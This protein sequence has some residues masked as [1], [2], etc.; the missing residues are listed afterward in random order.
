MNIIHEQYIG[1]YENAFSEEYCNSV[2]TYFEEM[3]KSGNTQ[4]RQQ[5]DGVQKSIKENTFINCSDNTVV[6]AKNTSLIR[7]FNET[8]WTKCYSDYAN[9]YWV[10]NDFSNHGSFAFRIQKTEPGQGYHVWHCESSTRE[11]AT[12]ILVWTLY[13]NNVEVGGETEFIYQQMRVNPK[14]AL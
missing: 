4:N 3:N 7:Q 10:L 5:A 1:I 9:K 14:Q 6:L 11:L 13:L 2:I 8:L 12:R